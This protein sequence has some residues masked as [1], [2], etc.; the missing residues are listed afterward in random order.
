MIQET[1][2]LDDI[3]RL[4]AEHDRYVKNSGEYHFYADEFNMIIK[5]MINQGILRSK[6]SN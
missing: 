4:L 2:T 6:G 1:R 5:A 3:K